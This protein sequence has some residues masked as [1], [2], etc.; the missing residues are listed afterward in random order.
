MDYVFNWQ[1]RKFKYYNASGRCQRCGKAVP[2]NQICCA[3]CAQQNRVDAER[4]RDY[5]D[6]VLSLRA[7]LH[8]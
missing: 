3:P 8:W 7:S 1:Q 6:T 2:P 4:D 5:Q